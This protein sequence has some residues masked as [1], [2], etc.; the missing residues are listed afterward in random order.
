MFHLD[1]EFYR[2]P[3]RFDAGRIEEEVLQFSEDEWRAHPQGHAGN[4]ALPLVSVGGGLNDDVKGPMRPTPLLARCPYLQQVLASLGT[5]IGRARLMR[6]AGQHDATPHVDTNYYWM[7]HVRVHIPAITYPE[8]RFLCLDQSVHMAAGECWIFD[9]WKTHNVINPVE[10]PRIHLVADTVGSAHFWSLVDR[11]SE[12]A[13][14]V[15]YDPSI[16]SPGLTFEDENYPVVMNPFEQQALVRRMLAGLPA[17][18]PELA[19]VLERLHQQWHAL[20]TAHRDAE[21]GWPAYR[22]AIGAFD[23]ELPALAGDL[24]LRNGV[25]LIEALRQ[26][27]V[28]PALSPEILERRAS[29]HATPVPM[30]SPAAP[31]APHVLSS[32]LIAPVFIVSAPRSGSSMLFE[33]LARSPDVWT[34]GGESHLVI[35]SLPKLDPIERGYDSNRLTEADADP[36]SVRELQNAFF[37][38]LRDREGR[39]VSTSRGGVRMLEKT[40]KNALRIPFLAAAFPGARFIFLYREP[41]GNISSILD[42]WRSQKFVT[43]P[44]L[45]DWPREEKWSMLLLEGWRALADKPLAGIAARQWLDANTQILNDLIDLPPDAWCAISYDEVCADPQRAAERVS[46]FAGWRW[47]VKLDAPLPH[48][49]HTLTPPDPEKWRRNE[50]EIAPFLPDADA[51]AR[52]A[53]VALQDLPPR[54]V[55]NESAPQVVIP[56]MDFN[57]EHTST[58]PELLEVLGISLAVSTYQAGKLMFLRA[59]DGVLNTH[60][61]DF[62]SPMGLAYRDGFL[63]LGTKNEAWT[64][65]AFAEPAVQIEPRGTHDALFL[66]AT[67]YTTG[68]IRIHEI[69]WAGT[70]LWAVN[71]RF[72]CLCTFDGR[73]NF[74]P[75]WRP[76]FITALAPEDRCHLNGVAFVEDLPAYVTCLGA[77]DAPDGWRVNKIDGGLLLDV[78]TGEIIARGLSMPH[79]PRYYAGK[80]WLLESGLGRLSTVDVASGKTTT[81]AELPGFTRGID[82]H[83][84]FAFIGLSQVRESAVFNGLA[85]CQPGRARECGVWVVDIRSGETVAFLRFSGSV[86]EIF[87]VQALPVRWPE[88][89]NEDHELLAGAFFVPPDALAPAPAAAMPLEALQAS[90]EWPAK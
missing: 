49:R 45:P 83:G 73:H 51:V 37:C 65:R 26:A 36:D 57:S 3:L 25:P 29:T 2:L 11:A 75:R 79:S 64:F 19:H 71:T 90:G 72:S 24:A 38:Q 16:P 54:A 61:R 35:E 13:K 66:P 55:S 86:Q 46:E 67:R 18:A 14:F 63:A 88:L 56:A 5:V 60:F 43:Y 81:V 58:F 22:A 28:R 31:A 9:S 80:L 53:A 84:P 82:F 78:A 48:S 30:P 42:A 69:A 68:D 77:T 47:D 20:W 39:L 27:I 17:P 76:P 41:R 33:L 12:G 62:Q 23:A 85:I 59:R 32:P 6:I 34:L 21:A 50:A 44:E 8:V 1:R 4:T 89:L 70:E 40:P 10:A 74:V 15:P 87:A 52:R 7:H